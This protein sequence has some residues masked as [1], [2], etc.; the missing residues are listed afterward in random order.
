MEPIGSTYSPVKP[1]RGHLVGVILFRST[2]MSL[3]VDF[4][5]MTVKLPVSNM[6]R[7]ILWLAM[8]NVTINALVCGRETP[9]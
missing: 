1:T 7:C 5:K 6:I 3:K 9:T 8:A 4:Y 2:V